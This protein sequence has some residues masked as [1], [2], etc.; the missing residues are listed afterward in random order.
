MPLQ[1]QTFLY[2][3]IPPAKYPLGNASLARKPECPRIGLP[4]PIP[5]LAALLRLDLSRLLAALLPE[6]LNVRL[7][8]G[9]VVGIDEQTA[10]AQCPRKLPI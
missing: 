7:P 3:A 5:I 1:R 4:K 8:T 10:G 2:P 9:N 6:L